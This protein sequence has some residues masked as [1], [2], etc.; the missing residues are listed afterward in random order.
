MKCAI[1]EE[2][3]IFLTCGTSTTP[4]RWIVLLTGVTIPFVAEILVGRAR[5][6]RGMA[7]ERFLH[8]SCWGVCCADEGVGLD[9]RPGE[10]LL[11]HRSLR[12]CFCRVVDSLY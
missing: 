4:P 1:E 7:A 8:A 9:K 6:A 5:T 2:I 3:D 11:R 12:R 10:R